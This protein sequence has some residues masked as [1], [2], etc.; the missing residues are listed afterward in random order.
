MA[1]Q[2]GLA[3]GH[4]YWF[5]FPFAVPNMPIPHGSLSTGLLI[6]SVEDMARYMIA[7]LN[8]GRYGDVQILSGA[9][10]DEL[11]RGA[12]GF[13]AMGRSLGQYGM[14]WFVD[15][16]SQTKLVW[17]SGTLPDFGAY[18]ALLPEQTRGVV[19]LVNANH[20]WM[21]PVLSTFGGGVVALLAGDQP[22]PLPFVG[23]IPWTLRGLLLIPAL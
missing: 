20:H 4:Q 16:I 21:N 7:L 3:V 5:A 22:A 19:L 10:I 14:G 17:H 11:H 8:G 15:E 1:K 2:N 9:S 13:S 18:M 12:D 23:M 6:S